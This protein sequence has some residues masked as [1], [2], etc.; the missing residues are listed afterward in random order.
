MAFP[1][2]DLALVD[3]LL[4]AADGQVDVEPKKMFGCTALFCRGHMVAG[5]FGDCLNLRLGE[6]DRAAALALPGAHP[7]V[8]MEGRPMREYVCLPRE[9]AEAPREL[10]AWLEKGFGF[11]RGLPPKAPKAP[12]VPKAKPARTK[13]A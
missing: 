12:K 3:L 8:P 6:I 10:R 11:V 2:P 9:V 4:D 1:K 13:G 5:V 7:F